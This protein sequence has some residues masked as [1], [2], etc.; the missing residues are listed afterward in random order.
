MPVSCRSVSRT[1]EFFRGL[2]RLPKSRSKPSSALDQRAGA[3]KGKVSSPLD[4]RAGAAGQRIGGA[5]VGRF[6]ATA[7]VEIEAAKIGKVAM[8][9]S[10]S[11]D[12]NPDP[13][14]V[15]WTW[16]P[17]EENDGRGKDR[18]VLV[19]ANLKNGSVLAVQLTSKAH[20]GDREFLSLGTGSWDAE[21]RASW[22]NLDR[23]FQVHPDGMRREAASLD[24]TRF[25]RVKGALRSRYSWS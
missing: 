24:K 19:V 4:P 10:P 7:T 18:P 2:F 14:E 21:N 20:E 9:Y 25:D 3:A 15:V 11:V 16:V 22:V 1:S 17:F 5:E 8:T 13:G 23:V 6:G 12:G